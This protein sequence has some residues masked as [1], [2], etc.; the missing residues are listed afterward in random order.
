M[1]ST[2]PNISSP[3]HDNGRLPDYMMLD[4]KLQAYELLL[5]ALNC[6]IDGTPD[7]A[8]VDTSTMEMNSRQD[9]HNIFHIRTTPASTACNTINS[10]DSQPNAYNTSKVHMCNI[11]QRSI[12][13]LLTKNS[14]PC[15]IINYLET[16]AARLTEPAPTSYSSKWAR[17]GLGPS[18]GQ[19][20]AYSQHRLR[21]AQPGGSAAAASNLP[22]SGSIQRKRK[23]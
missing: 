11:P 10:K 15:P 1:E 16:L 13:I 19:P 12:E 7:T 8:W 22:I 20:Q 2:A 9:D 5:V 23:V 14:D 6:N 3:N 17:R 21:G 18:P 4:D